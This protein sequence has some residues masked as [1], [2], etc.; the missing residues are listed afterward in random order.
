MELKH[1]QIEEHMHYQPDRIHR[2]HCLLRAMQAFFVCQKH[3]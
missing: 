1:D 2:N 3:A